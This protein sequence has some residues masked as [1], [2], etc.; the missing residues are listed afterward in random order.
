MLHAVIMAGGSGTRFWPQSRQRL[1]KQLLRLAGE[2]TM[3]QQTLDRCGDLIA[4]QQAWIVTNATQADLTRQQLPALPPEN[5]L[6]EPAAR[7]TAP[8]VGLAAVHAVQRDPDA[9]M[10]VMPADHVISPP[11]KF[12]QALSRAAA[13]VS[14]F[15]DRLVLFGVPP[16][17]PATGF[18]YIERD[19]PLD[20]AAGVFEVSTFREKPALDVAEQYVAAG[21]FYW[22][23][24]IF[25]WRA[26][27]ILKQLETFQPETHQRLQTLAEAIGTDRYDAVLA[28]QFPQMNSVS[29]D[30]AVLEQATGVTVIEAPFTWDDVGSWLAVPRLIGQDPNGNTVDGPFAG[31]DTKNCIVRSTPDHLIATLGVD[32]LIIVHTEDATLVARRQ[33]S[34]RIKDLLQELKQRGDDQYL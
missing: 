9:V 26:D 31:V 19:I 32:D 24:G 30:V 10:L 2:R 14:Q 27:T 16:T 20:E 11:E 29:I 18:G 34:E 7:N 21:N 6:V 33:D 17:F 3:I 25:C 22:N 8:C 4:P 5:V 13:V 15:P 12:Q 1:P 28:E 23:C